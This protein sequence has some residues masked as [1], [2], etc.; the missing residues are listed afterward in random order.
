MLISIQELF[1]LFSPSKTID[2]STTGEEKYDSVATTSTPQGRCRTQRSFWMKRA[3]KRSLTFAG[4]TK[5]FGLVMDSC[6]FM[7]MCTGMDQ[8]Q[9]KENR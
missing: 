5:F 2:G 9:N 4:G 3:G 8:N 7:W 6:G 1:G